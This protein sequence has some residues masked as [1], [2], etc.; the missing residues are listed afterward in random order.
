MH[1]RSLLNAVSV[2]PLDF[3]RSFNKKVLNAEQALMLTLL[4][5]A[6]E[7]FQEYVH[8]TERHQK[9]NC[10]TKRLATFL[11]TRQEFAKPALT[12]LATTDFEVWAKE[13]LK[14]R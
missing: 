11:R 12:E 13:A 14:Q 8:C 2:D 9:T 3:E 7:D 1:E 10:S 6:V 5:N 4:R